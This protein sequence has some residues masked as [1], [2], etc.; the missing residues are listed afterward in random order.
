MNRLFIFDLDGTLIDSSQQILEATNL[1]LAKRDL[2]RLT[3]AFLLP[4]IGLPPVHFFAKFE[5][6]DMEIDDLVTEFRNNLISIATSNL[7]FFPG[8]IELLSFLKENG[9][10]VAIATNKPTNVTTTLM[11]S[12]PAWAFVDICVGTGEVKPK[13]SPEMIFRIL[14]YFAHA[15]ILKS[16]VRMIG[17]RN[18]DVVCGLQA[19][20]LTVLLEQSGH[21]LDPELHGSGTLIFSNIFDY[22]QFLM[23]SN[24]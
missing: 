9:D 12:S 14:D 19:G 15:N 13:P 5:L 18:E 10:F 3:E 20:I 6:N 22:F 21:R 4:L 7:V 8:A 16:E 1:A 11:K 24:P 23:K 2:P 17:D